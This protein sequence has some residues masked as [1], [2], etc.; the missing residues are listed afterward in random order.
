MSRLTQFDMLLVNELFESEPGYI[1][2]FSN[3]TFA[4]FFGRE[5]GVN[6]DDPT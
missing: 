3:S 4:A 2:N 1:L 6:I 5:L